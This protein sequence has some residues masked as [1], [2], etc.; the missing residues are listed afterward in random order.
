MCKQHYTVVAARVKNLEFYFSTFFFININHKNHSYSVTRTKACLTGY[1]LSKILDDT[2][3]YLLSIQHL[4]DT[5]N[6]VSL[7]MPKCVYCCRGNA[8]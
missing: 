8:P 5:V 7:A 3:F 1:F 4:C 6:L 2:P